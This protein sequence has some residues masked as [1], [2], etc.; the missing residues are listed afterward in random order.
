MQGRGDKKLPRMLAALLLIALLATLTA[1]GG[2]GAGN[3]NGNSAGGGGTADA[4]DNSADTGG[5]ADTAGGDAGKSGGK[6]TVTFWN[7]FTA[8]D[9]E[10]LKEI[11]KKYNEANA[12]KVEIKMDI[13]P[14]DQLYQKL[15]PSIAT[16]TAPN[17]ILTG[18]ATSLTYIENGSFLDISD[19]FTVTGS[20]PN[21]FVEAALKLGQLDGK[22]YLIPMQSFSQFLY[23]NKDLFQAAGLDPEKPPA[24]WDELGQLAEKLTDPK[25]NQFGIGLPVK[26][27]LPYYG[28]L[29]IANGGDAV[30]VAAKKS[31]VYSEENLNSLQWLQNL[32]RKKVSPKGASGADLDK[33]MNSG[34]LA[35]YINGP[36]LINGLR[37]NNINFG[38][39]QLPKGSVKQATLMDMTGYAVIKGTNDEQKK[40]I[41]DFIHYWNSTEIGKEWS[42]R[43]GFPPYLK[44]VIDDPEVK[45]DPTVS[46]LSKMGD[47]AQ[48]WLVGLKSSGKI[49]TDAL[50]PMIEAIQSGADVDK[51]LK[52]ASDKIDELLKTE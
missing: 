5:N 35:M 44:S 42:M 12:G 10:V 14:W 33:V 4:Q 30:D 47:I 13:M 48:T 39:T 20:D 26:G 1:C 34:K 27:A 22:Q 16:N 32:A 9:G 2:G 18:P 28:S 19:F 50:F 21:N 52:K 38:V 31:V 17:L 6:V 36:W 23:W 15:P 40:A 29:L 49:D 25:K 3:G 45:A 51:E 46:E 24:T 43:N 7:G 8:S 41:Y 37:E 11:V